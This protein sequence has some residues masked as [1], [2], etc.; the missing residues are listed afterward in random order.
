M[1]GDLPHALNVLF[2]RKVNLEKTLSTV[3]SKISVCFTTQ[4]RDDV[5][6]FYY[7]IIIINQN[8]NK[9]LKR[10]WLSAAWFEH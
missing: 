3:H 4:E 9:I 7:P 5:T 2:M 1:V 6:T 10:D 8:Y